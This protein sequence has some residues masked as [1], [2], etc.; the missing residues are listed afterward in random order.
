MIF[1][2]SVMLSV[3]KLFPEDMVGELP[4]MVADAM[5]PVPAI[6]GKD[7]PSTRLVSAADTDES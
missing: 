7:I 5:G 6:P 4:E 1:T 3:G 2:L